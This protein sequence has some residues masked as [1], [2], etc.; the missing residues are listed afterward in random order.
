MPSQ[1][2]LQQAKHVFEALMLTVLSDGRAE[3]EEAAIVAKLRKDDPVLA[4]V[5]DIA[6]VGTELRDRFH[7]IGLEPCAKAIAAGLRDRHYQELAFIVCAKVMSADGE[8]ELEEAELLG[9]FQELFAFTPA[10][11][12]RL[13]AHARA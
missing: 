8:M 11:V 13:I 9:I 4:S 12:K 7:H 5:A 10:D 2:D 6:A 1:I 3:I